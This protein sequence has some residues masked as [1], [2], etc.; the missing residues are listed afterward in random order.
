MLRAD[1]EVFGSVA[2]AIVEKAVEFSARH[3][4]R[5][6]LF[7]VTRELIDH[8]DFLMTDLFGRAEPLKIL[9]PLLVSRVRGGATIHSFSG[10]RGD[11][12]KFIVLNLNAKK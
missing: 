11:D 6:N 10:D 9:Y 7:Y 5:G 12:A 2:D 8:R 1:E 4:D 3:P